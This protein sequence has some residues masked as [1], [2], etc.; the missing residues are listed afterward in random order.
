MNTYKFRAECLHD[1]IQFM[2]NYPE[3]LIGGIEIKKIDE[4]FTDLV[5]TITTSVEISDILNSF[6]KMEGD[7]HVMFESLQDASCY[8]GVRIRNYFESD[9]DTFV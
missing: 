4:R 2:V 5:V 8:N 1:V 9:I 7:V 6:L 3:F